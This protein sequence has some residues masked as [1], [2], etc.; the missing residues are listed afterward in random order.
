MAIRPY[1]SRFAP[2]LEG[3][4]DGLGRIVTAGGFERMLSTLHPDI[5]WRAPVLEVPGTGSGDIYLG[6]RGLVLAPSLF[7]SS[8]AEVLIRQRRACRASVAAAAIRTKASPAAMTKPGFGPAS[9]SPSRTAPMKSI[10]AAPL[11]TVYQI[12]R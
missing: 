9:R 7:L 1:W 10:S 12:N 4:R 3:E 8:G 5:C 11:N 6:G 2:V